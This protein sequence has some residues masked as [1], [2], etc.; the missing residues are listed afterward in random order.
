MSDGG[1]GFVDVLHAALGGRPA[2]RSPSP[3][4]TASPTPATILRV[5]ETA[6]VESAQ[7]VGLHLTEPERPRARA[8]DHAAASVSC[9]ATPSTPAPPGSS[10][11]WA[12]PATNDA[13]AGLLVGPRR[14]GRGRRRS[15]RGRPGWRS[16]PPST[17]V[18]PG[19]GVEGVELVL[20]SD[21]DNPLLGINGATKIYGPQKGL[22]EERLVTVDGWLQHFAELTDRKLAAAEG[23]RCSRRPGLRPAAA[24]GH[25]RSRAST[26]WP[27]RS[28]WR[29]R[30]AAPTSWSPARAP[31]TSP[32]ASGQGAVRRRGGRR[33][34]AGAV[35]R[36]RRARCWSAPGRC[37]RWASSRRTRWSTWW[38][39]SAR[40]GAP[41]EAL[42]E[43]ATRTART[44]SR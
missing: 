43:L 2:T 21:V 7:A 35:H 1:P 36:P 30:C 40:S 20:A 32:R 28:D 31:S 26:W 25:P 42:A 9:S 24:R 39:R 17:W 12:A 34:A 44:W 10:S 23:R 22:P 33:P 27:R 11:A 15:T 5:G 18:P 37:G 3:T 14:H 19:D 41:A 29:S 16:S 13:G 38:G 4:R 6:Y 8:G